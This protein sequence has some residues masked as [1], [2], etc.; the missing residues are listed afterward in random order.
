MYIPTPATDGFFHTSVG[1]RPAIRHIEWNAFTLQ[2][3]LDWA[4]ENGI[5]PASVTISAEA[6]YVV[7]DIE[8][9]DN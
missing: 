4:A 1:T 6:G 5:D 7:P 3:L 8:V 9:Y 2:E